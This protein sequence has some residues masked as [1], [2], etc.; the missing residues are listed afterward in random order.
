MGQLHVECWLQT[1]WVLFWA[2]LTNHHSIFCGCGW[3]PLWWVGL[4]T[5]KQIMCTATKYRWWQTRGTQSRQCN[6]GRWIVNTLVSK[7]PPPSIHQLPPPLSNNSLRGFPT[8]V[9]SPKLF[10]KS[11]SIHKRY[12]VGQTCWCWLVYK[13]KYL[14][15]VEGSYISVGWTANFG[16]KYKECNG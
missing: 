4:V 6:A 5:N 15:S 12:N 3:W 1:I 16:V 2:R 11:F 9:V 13:Y 7:Y 8:L 14:V 10:T